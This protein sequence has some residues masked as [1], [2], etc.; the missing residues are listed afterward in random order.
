MMKK[1][2]EGE[3]KGLGRG[4]PLSITRVDTS[5][6]E[7]TGKAIDNEKKQWYQNWVSRE[8]DR[9]QEN[10]EQLDRRKGRT[11]NKIFSKK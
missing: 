8:A 2:T 4:S 11:I 6:S 5:E 10:N 7:C 1:D 9:G 3:Y